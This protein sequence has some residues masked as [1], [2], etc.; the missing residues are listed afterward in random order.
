MFCETDI[1][2]LLM[3]SFHTSL[4]KEIRKCVMLL[5]QG[6]SAASEDSWK[7][8]SG[9]VAISLHWLSRDPASSLSFFLFH[10]L[11][12]GPF[13]PKRT[14]FIIQ[15]LLFTLSFV[16]RSIWQVPLKEVIDFRHT[17]A[18]PV[19]TRSTWQH[20][21]Q[22]AHSVFLHIFYARCCEIKLSPPGRYSGGIIVQRW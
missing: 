4:E 22:A 3:I 10:L 9:K 5:L 1:S 6:P 2:L 16:F 21:M 8:E 7:G 11:I 12:H 13:S 20:R 15:L 17:I 19:P 18:A 14:A